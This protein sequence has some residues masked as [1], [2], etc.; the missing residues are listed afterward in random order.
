MSASRH[1]LLAL[2]V[3]GPAH[4]YRLNQRLQA[5]LGPEWEINSGQMSRE[6]RTLE[7]EGL[8]RPIDGAEGSQGRKRVM[9]LTEDGYIQ[10]ERW[11]VG[12]AAGVSV[13][14][15]EFLAKVNLGGPEHR[16]ASL[17]HITTHEAECVEKLEKL[18]GIRDRTPIFPV[19]TERL[20]KRCATICEM[21]QFEAQLHAAMLVRETIAVA[22]ENRAPWGAATAHNDAAA[23]RDREEAREEIFRR[24]LR[25]RIDSA[26]GEDGK[27]VE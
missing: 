15:P 7:R 22:S 11:L 1:T 17:R 4:G 18:Q 8:V 21:W 10:A 23:V 2:L 9:E 26:P 19:V 20:L 24:M 27:R 13:S 12:D 5:K 25:S 16:E 3:E 6:L 14:S